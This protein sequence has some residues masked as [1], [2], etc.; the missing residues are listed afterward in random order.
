MFVT[1]NLDIGRF[2][3][4]GGGWVWEGPCGTVYYFRRIPIESYHYGGT[5]DTSKV[6][7]MERNVMARPLY[8]R[9]R[10]CVTDNRRTKGWPI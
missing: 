4:L 2:V 10:A 7:D 5:L 9:Y 8:G 3:F 6:H 1:S